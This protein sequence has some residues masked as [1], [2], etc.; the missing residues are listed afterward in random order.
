[1]PC[2]D[3]PIGTKYKT[4]GT[5]AG[6]MIGTPSIIVGF[7]VGDGLLRGSPIHD[8]GKIAIFLRRVDLERVVRHFG[9][10]TGPEHPAAARSF[11]GRA[12]IPIERRRQDLPADLH[13]AGLRIDFDAADHAVE[14]LLV[15]V[16]IGHAPFRQRHGEARRA[17]ECI[18]VFSV[19]NDEPWLPIEFGIG[20]RI[21]WVLKSRRSIRAMRLLALSLTNS[22]RP[23]Y[24]EFGLRKRR[25]MHVAPGKI[26]E[27]L[28][29]FVIEAVTGRRV[30]REDGD[31]R[32]VSHRWN[33]RD[34][35]LA[36]MSAGIEEIIFVLLS[37]SDVT[38]ERVRGAIA[39]DVP[40]LFSAAREA[41]ALR[42][43]RLRSV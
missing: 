17:Q 43:V 21:W 3:L 39:C 36:G 30:R 14:F 24:F 13:L 19:T 7:A 42:R 34:E 23:S 11:A 8:R 26:A 16:R 37:G 12:E 4:P 10:V 25:V 28:L 2:G 27:H 35:D 40:A 20:P 6:S 15:I 22:Q 5:F 41:K 1:M 33:A 18:R 31:G 29:R 9:V 38:G 32:D